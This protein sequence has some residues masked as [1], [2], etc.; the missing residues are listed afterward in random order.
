MAL[1]DGE[2]LEQWRAQDQDGSL[3]DDTSNAQSHPETTPSR[4]QS[5]ASIQQSP[6]D[7]LLKPNLWSSYMPV[8]ST[9]SEERLSQA[10]SQDQKRQLR[11]RNVWI[12]EFLVTFLSLGC[13]CAIGIILATMHGRPLARWPLPISPNALISVFAT[14]SKSAM[15]LALAEGISQ[16]KWVYFQRSAHRLK[17]F[18][19]FDDASRGPWG[20][21]K[22]I[23]KLNIRAIVAAAGALIVIMSLAMDPFVQQILT[24][25]TDMVVAIN[26]TATIGVATAFDSG[27]SKRQSVGTYGQSSGPYPG[28]WD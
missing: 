4:Q 8:D 18:Q 9:T 1:Q 25:R 11:W 16:L 17:D 24:F 5:T 2:Y 13:M 28:D 19:I 21:V 27:A 22:L 12:W 14:V 23:A 20:A 7:G 15:L 3:H 6:R 26:G 10:P